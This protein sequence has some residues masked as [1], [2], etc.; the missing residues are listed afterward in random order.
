MGDGRVHGVEPQVVGPLLQG[1][2]AAVVVKKCLTVAVQAVVDGLG[3]VRVPG[4][5]HQV[6]IPGQGQG[7]VLVVDRPV[8]PLNGVLRAV[9]EGGRRL[10]GLVF[11]R[12]G[13]RGY[14]LLGQLRRRGGRGAGLISRPAGAQH[15]SHSKKKGQIEPLHVSASISFS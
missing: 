11:R 15:Q 14:G 5:L 1:E 13:G 7:S 9:G 12:L 3:L 4:E 6:I 8:L 2:I 10:L